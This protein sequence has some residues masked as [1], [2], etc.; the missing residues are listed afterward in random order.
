MRSKLIQVCAL[1]A[2]VS[3][4][5]AAGVRSSETQFN[6][7]TTS[8][9]ARTFDVISALGFTSGTDTL[10]WMILCNKE[11]SA[12]DVFYARFEINGDAG[13]FDC[14]DDP[15]NCTDWMPLKPSADLVPPYCYDTR[16][17]GL[18]AITGAQID[19]GCSDCGGG[20]DAASYEAWGAT[21]FSLW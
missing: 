15:G 12:G 16:Q 4:L 2:I 13:D 5:V 19:V 20:D 17:L 10:A 9:S 21:E 11:A 1:L 18:E 8:A 6:E 7:G 3:F 14:D